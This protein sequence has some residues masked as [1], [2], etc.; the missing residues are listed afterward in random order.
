MK[1][2]HPQRSWIWLEP[3]DWRQTVEMQSAPDFRRWCEEEQ[4]QRLAKD[5][6]YHQQFEDR[7]AWLQRKMETMQN[8]IYLGRL[9]LEPAAGMARRELRLLLELVDA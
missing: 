8:E 4:L 6:H 5:P 1:R 3:V 9:D 2:Q 7:I